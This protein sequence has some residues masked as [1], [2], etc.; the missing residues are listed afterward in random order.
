M[1]V[2]MHPYHEV[3]PPDLQKEYDRLD[4][5][6]AEHFKG[7]IDQLRA[8]AKMQVMATHPQFNL[9]RYDA[10]KRT[11]LQLSSDLERA[12]NNSGVLK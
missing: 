6:V 12:L 10:L 1:S 7:A 4:T 9:S 3:I 5:A 8:L 11:A 2:V